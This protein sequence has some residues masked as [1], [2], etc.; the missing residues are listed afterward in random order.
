[1]LTKTWLTERTVFVAMAPCLELAAKDWVFWNYNALILMPNTEGIATDLKMNLNSRIY[2]LD[3]NF[4]LYEIFKYGS[5]NSSFVQK[6]IGNTSTTNF[7]GKSEYIWNRRS[8]L[9]NV[10]L[11]IIY[12]GYPPIT[13]KGDSIDDVRGLYGEIF[14]ALQ[15]KLQFQ[16]TMNHQEDNIWGT[17]QGNGSYSGLFGQMQNEKVNWSIADTTITL[18][19]SEFFDFSLP[20][21]HQHKKL[22]TRKPQEDFNYTS[23]ISVF[24]DQFWIAL[25][26]S[27]FVLALFMFWILLNNSY[28]NEHKSKCLTTAMTFT[29]LSLFGREIFSLDTNWSGKIICL[30]VVVWG[31]LISVSYNAILTSVLAS[32]TIVPTLDSLE[33]LLFS[34]DYTLILKADGSTREYF[35]KAQENSIG[36]LKIL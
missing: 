26:I 27:A 22:L 34:R 7:V 10:H 21:V 15:E 31:F 20:L 32:S 8:N 2:H 16:Y 4:S 1:M 6:M 3:N 29:M 25:L 30:V 18:E 19:R 33:D 23:Y 11:G 9:S 35:A 24:S 12:G 14:Y 17:L 36:M 13:W 5:L 28:N